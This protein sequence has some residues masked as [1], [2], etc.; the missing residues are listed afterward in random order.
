[1]GCRV[2]LAR[3]LKK[4]LAPWTWWDEGAALFA[5]LFGPCGKPVLKSLQIAQ[6]LASSAS[7]SRIISVLGYGTNRAAQEL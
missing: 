4:G 6:L 3:L 5:D 7:M 2:G 1:M